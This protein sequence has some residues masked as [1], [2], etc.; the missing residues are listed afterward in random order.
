MKA[1]LSN[2]GK[3]DFS[4]LDRCF[5]NPHSTTI[6]FWSHWWLNLFKKGFVKDGALQ[7]EKKN[8][9]KTQADLNFYDENGNICGAI[10]VENNIYCYALDVENL[11]HYERFDSLK[12]LIIHVYADV[13]ENG[14]YKN[15][16]STHEIK[17]AISKIIEL[18]SPNYWIIVISKWGPNQEI[19]KIRF[20]G[21]SDLSLIHI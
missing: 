16:K 14:N 3:F 4:K 19:S 17:K 5:D 1:V 9:G 15:V 11:A 8:G 20:S 10:E 12:F 6:G 13:D 2:I 7:I 21:I 18:K